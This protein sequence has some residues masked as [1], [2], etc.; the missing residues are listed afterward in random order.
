MQ[1]RFGSLAEENPN[2][3]DDARQPA[4]A[5]QNNIQEDDAVAGI[6]VNEDLQQQAHT[7]T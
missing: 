1:T 2:G 5:S 6:T 3:V 4:E 7:L